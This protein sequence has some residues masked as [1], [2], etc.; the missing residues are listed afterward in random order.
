[1]LSLTGPA[2][3]S[4]HTRLNN[5]SARWRIVPPRGSS[6]PTKLFATGELTWGSAIRREWPDGTHDLV[7]FTVREGT[8]RRRIRSDERISCP[9]LVG[10]GE[11]G[12]W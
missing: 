5:L 4:V 6:D 2:T 9:T 7:S 8:V 10:R 1:M 12:S 3:A 11:G